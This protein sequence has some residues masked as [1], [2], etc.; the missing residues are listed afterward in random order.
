MGRGFGSAELE[1]QS[2]TLVFRNRAASVYLSRGPRGWQNLARV[3]SFY[4]ERGVPQEA[5]VAFVEAV[6]FDAV[7][8]F[9][10]HPEDGTPAAA[11]DGAVPDD[12]KHQRREAIM[13]AQRRIAFDANARRVGSTVRVLVDGTDARGDCVGRTYGQAPEVDGICSLTAARPAG[14]GTRAGRAGRTLR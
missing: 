12:L 5:A 3:G 8:V 2:W 4:R 13:L 7:G 10:F 6:G 1:G 9:V 14:R 11:L